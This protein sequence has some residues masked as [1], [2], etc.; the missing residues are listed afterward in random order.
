MQITDHGRAYV[1][2]RIERAHTITE[3]RRFWE[4]ELADWPKRDTHIQIAKEQKKREL[5]GRS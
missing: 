2:S 4:D 1:L 5:T 3:L